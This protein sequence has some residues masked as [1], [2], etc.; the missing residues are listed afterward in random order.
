MVEYPFVTAGVD[1]RTGEFVYLKGRARPMTF[2][3]SR[4]L[5]DVPLCDTDAV[6]RWLLS[7]VPTEAEMDAA[8][9]AAVARYGFWLGAAAEDVE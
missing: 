1:I 8:R 3:E 5:Y 6:A 9:E 7:M 4:S 2:R